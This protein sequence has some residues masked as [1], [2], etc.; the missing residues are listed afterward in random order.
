MYHKL[1]PVPFKT[2]DSNTSHNELEICALAREVDSTYA[3]NIV[4]MIAEQT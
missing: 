2:Q 4:T 3:L 1:L